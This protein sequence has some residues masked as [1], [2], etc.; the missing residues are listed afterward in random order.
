VAVVS[1]HATRV[2]VSLFEGET[3]VA[4][5]PLRS[6]LGDVHFG[7]V[8][9]LREGTHYGLRA[10]GP[11]VPGEGHRFD[12]AKLLLDPHASRIT[13]AFAH[14]PDLM[15]HGA[16]TARLVPK[17]IAGHSAADAEPLAP[18]RPQFIYEI[19]VRAFTWR[20]LRSLRI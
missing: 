18:H 14:H 11:W 6:R 16:E 1:R 3:E 2:F 9:G 17:A 4:R 13:S 12:P 15:R 5:I 10:E 8:P 19:P 20:S 7:F